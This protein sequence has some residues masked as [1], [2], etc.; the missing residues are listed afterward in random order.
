MKRILV[1]NFFPAFT[2]P[3]S[4]GELR[5]FNLYNELSSYYDIT[6]LSPTYSHHLQETIEHSKTFREHRIPK[7]P[8]HDLLHQQIAREAISPEVS[9]LV[10]ALSSKYP[11]NYH[12]AYLNLYSNAD[13]IVH[14]SPYML[15]YDLFIGYDKKLRIYNSYN[16]ESSLVK[17]V[18]NGVN[19]LKYIDY[20]WSLESR[21]LDQCELCFAVSR[22]EM[23]TFIREFGADPQKM[24]VAPNGINP[25]KDSGRSRASSGTK[26]R[27]S[28]LFF[29]SL[30]PPNIAAA[31]FIV[32]E[33]AEECPDVDFIIAG[34]C[35]NLDS[36]AILSSNVRMLG[37][38]NDD[39]KRTLL[40]DAD[41]ALN[42]MFTGAGT[43]LKI[44]EY[45]SYGIP[46]VSTE[47]GTRGLNLIAN[48]H[49]VI[50]DRHD[51]A[52]KLC[53]LLTD[54][55]QRHKISDQGKR[56]VENQYS[57]HS[58]AA[59]VKE[60]L[61]SAWDSRRS[62][63]E[64]ILFVLNDFEVNVPTSGGEIRINRIYSHLSKKYKI[65]LLCLNNSGLIIRTN[66][67]DSFAQMS[68]PKTEEHL[69]EQEKVNSSFSISVNDII[70]SM[71]VSKN[72]I[73]AAVARA[74][75]GICDAVI[76]SHPYMIGLLSEINGKPIIY[77]SHNCEYDLKES[78]LKGHPLYHELIETVKKCETE[79]L[80]KSKLVIS[81]SDDD[82][83]RLRQLCDGQKA[84]HTIPNGVDFEERLFGKEAFPEI[85]RMFH[86]HPVI[87]FVGSAH[88]PNLDCMC[89][90]RDL[91]APAMPECFFL[92]IGSVCDAFRPRVPNN[93]LLCGKVDEDCKAVLIRLANL[94]INPVACGSGSNLKLAEYLANRIPVVTTPFGARGYTVESGKEAIV[95]E[96]PEFEEHIRILLKNPD[97]Q[98]SLAE[99][100]Y[101]YAKSKLDWSLLSRRYDEVLRRGVFRLPQRRL[102]VVTYRFTDPPLG[103]AE[104]HL[105]ELL[106]KIVETGDYEIDVATLD[107]KTI[108]NQFHFSC[109]YSFDMDGPTPSDLGDT[110]VY[111]FKTDCLPDEVKLS[112]ARMLFRQWMQESRESSLRHLEKYSSPLL[113]GGWNYP[114]YAQD[115]CEIWTSDEALIFVQDVEILNLRGFHPAKTKLTCMAGEEV[116]YEEVVRGEFEVKL[117]LPGHRVLKLLVNDLA[118][119]RNDPRTLGIRVR[120]AHYE[121]GGEGFA[122]RLDYD[123]KAHLRQYFLDAY[124]EEL[125]RV[126]ESRPHEF[127]VLFQTTRGPLSQALEEWLD[128]NIQHYDLVCGHSIPF[129]TSIMATRYARKYNKPVMMV[130]DFH[131]DDVFYHW[132]SYY[133]A[134]R[135][136]DRLISFPKA[137]SRLFYD[138]IGCR[139][140]YI[141]PGIY[142][143]GERAL[144]DIVA[145]NR[146]YGSVLPYV[147]VLGRKDR[148]KNYSLIID[149]VKK[150]NWKHRICHVVLIGRDE[151]GVFIDP[152]EAIYLGGQTNGIVL[153]AL[154]NSLCLISMSESESFG[155]VILEAWAQKRPVIVNENCIAFTELVDEGVN[156]LYAT[157]EDL[158]EKI[159][160]LLNN[161]A[162]GNQMGV[163]GHQKVLDAF[164]WDAVSKQLSQILNSLLRE[165]R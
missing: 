21:L 91:L 106:R 37:R 65:I 30:H 20:I 95:C 66:I 162:I 33:L 89:F 41:I 34:N 24:A 115:A 125:I 165:G 44:L 90:I 147:L 157:K 19:A 60:R 152:E 109:S 148:A 160:C 164:T 142:P 96:L 113:L 126:A 151:D 123:Y 131:I 101:R 9:A 74:L 18:W 69:H 143:H 121:I 111:R 6:L 132:K 82:H 16:V 57:W 71:Y 100:G 156:G 133:T 159:V 104:V 14:E 13:M 49:C 63:N 94:A 153:A 5:Y 8:I 138:K 85:V 144:E 36:K 128:Q 17:Q 48:E 108:K 146:L 73:A 158:H 130:P 140:T 137:A 150:V 80:V 40:A 79:A 102:L 46:T 50:A 154:R 23:D 155:I 68:L 110:R 84:I 56:F 58:I 116:L 87:L 105:L 77:E 25:V 107:L 52:T 7:E 39:V 135:Q 75:F 70:A 32:S 119:A 76:V 161:V 92:I 2:P 29:G 35:I 97:L 62:G 45:L 28:A 88:K 55:N 93:I 26:T 27:P 64:R 145:F 134:L 120:S 136:S 114:E 15:G 118:Q 129:A 47:L 149:A 61:I 12:K 10:C 72:Y 98:K 67:T 86:G 43:N 112:N 3:G 117:S 42:P 1:L 141:P 99:S 127:D 4:G 38:V 122:L 78:L 31:E 11:N 139:S 163:N 22:E 51:F 59:D 103:G 83:D 54:E 81:V 53:D 124:I